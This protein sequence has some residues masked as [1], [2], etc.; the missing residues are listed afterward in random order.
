M[1]KALLVSL[2]KGNG[3]SGDKATYSIVKTSPSGVASEYHLAKT[4]NGVTENI[5]D[6][7]DVPLDMVVQSGSVKTCT[8]ADV[9]VLGYKVGDK[10]IDLLIAN[11]N[12][13]HIYVLVNDLVDNNASGIKYSNTTS[14][15]AATNVQSA[16]DELDNSKS[17][18]THTHNYAASDSVGGSATSAKRLDNMTAIGS[19][20]QPVYFN[21]DGIPAATS[22]SV[23]KSV[24]SNAVFTDTV[25]TLPV[26]TKT[27]LGGGKAGNGL[28]I[29][30]AGS[31]RTVN[32]EHSWSKALSTEGWYRVCDM[33]KTLTDKN[34]LIMINRNFSSATNEVYLISLCYSHGKPV[35][36]LLNKSAQTAGITK[37]RLVYNSNLPYNANTYLEIYYALNTSNSVSVTMMYNTSDVVEFLPVSYTAGEIPDGSGS[38]V[39][40]LTLPSLQEQVDVMPQSKSIYSV[41]DTHNYHDFVI[42]L[43][44]ITTGNANTYFYGQIFLKR[45]NGSGGQITLLNVSCEKMFN[46]EKATYYMDKSDM[47]TA[48]RPCSFVYNSK[49]YFGIHVKITASDYDIIRI[50]AKTT[51]N[52][53]IITPIYIY[54]TNTSTAIN[55]EVYDSLNFNPGESKK[56]NFYAV[57]TVINQ[58]GTTTKI[59]SVSSSVPTSATATGVKG[60]VAYDAAY[61]YVCT[62]ANVWKRT[63]LSTW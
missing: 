25:Y 34:A 21:S 17:D 39:F 49:K 47:W 41:M 51:T 4:V 2:I 63:A 18:T 31:L 10:Y 14:G 3:G 20:T 23:A 32:Q 52:F 12:D 9:P 60:E 36:R 56:L 50:D 38:T 54:N 1:N 53:D 42:P 58:D 6:A 55:Q 27:T 19:V 35:F 16:I 37:I 48:I 59:L 57:P 26:A 5:G 22:Y 61:M 28:A 11:S 40:D 33:G 43:I 29:D 46:E 45:S 15:M 8:T 62:D 44:D 13:Q 30:V 7:I 24:P